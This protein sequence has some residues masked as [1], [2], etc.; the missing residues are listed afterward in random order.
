MMANPSMIYGYPFVHRQST[1]S[2]FGLSSESQN[3]IELTEF[4]ES[5]LLNICFSVHYTEDQTRTAT[6]I[7]PNPHN[8]LICEDVELLYNGQTVFRCQG[9]A[10]DLLSGSLWDSG[11]PGT[12]QARIN[13]TTSP[14][15]S[16]QVTGHVYQI[17]MADV[18]AMVYDGQYCN[19]SRY[20]SQ[21]MQLR[22]TPRNIDPNDTTVKV[23]EAHF[24]YLY[25]AIAEISNGVV[26][27]Q[28]S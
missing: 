23:C 5:D 27:I 6:G 8:S 22:I 28:F 18:K 17:P 21:T 11:A 14:Y 10:I 1:S 3:N 20:S 7:T 9:N 25:S 16:S 19:T 15:T 13:R 24:T 12:P 26:N 4:L 2:K